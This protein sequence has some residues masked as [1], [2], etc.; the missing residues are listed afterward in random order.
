[1]GGLA[2]DYCVRA[3][4]LDALGQGFRVTVLDDAIAG[5]DPADSARALDEM[6]TAGA[7]VTSAAAVPGPP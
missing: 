7:D 6:R 4:V 3:S 1:V 2:T 5:V